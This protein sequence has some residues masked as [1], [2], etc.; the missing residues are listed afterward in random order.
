MPNSLQF[1]KSFPDGEKTYKRVITIKLRWLLWD[2]EL[3]L[4]KSRV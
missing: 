3:L 1:K 4:R 2:Y